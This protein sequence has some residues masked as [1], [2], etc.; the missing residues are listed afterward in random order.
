MVN[1]ILLATTAYGVAG[2]VFAVAFAWRGVEVID[3]A[4]HGAPWTFRLLMIPGSAAL[5]PLL[6]LRWHRGIRRQ[7]SA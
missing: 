2:M 5:W 3:S 7:G 1:L 4:A 6:A